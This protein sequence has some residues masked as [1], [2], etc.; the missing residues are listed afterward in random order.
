MVP[1][2]NQTSQPLSL[3][4]FGFP[5]VCVCVSFFSQSLHY[6][7]AHCPFPFCAPTFL[8]PDTNWNRANTYPSQILSQPKIHSQSKPTTRRFGFVGCWARYR[9]GGIGTACLPAMDRH[10]YLACH[11]YVNDPSLEFILIK[12]LNPDDKMVPTRTTRKYGLHPLGW[13]RAGI[14]L[15]QHSTASFGAIYHRG[16]NPAAAATAGTLGL[17]GFVGKIVR[18][19][20]ISFSHFLLGLYVCVCVL[21]PSLSCISVLLYQNGPFFLFCPSPPNPFHSNIFPF[22][23]TNGLVGALVEEN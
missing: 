21:Y 16:W 15:P 14:R 23:Q 22:Q 2:L 7:F 17:V 5:T 12:H 1:N 4:S 20:D 8:R 11:Y 19:Q 13:S 3:H 9:E 6:S 18:I 10:P